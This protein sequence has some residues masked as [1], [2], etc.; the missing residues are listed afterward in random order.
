M[1]DTNGRHLRVGLT[2]WRVTRDIAGNLEVACRMIARAARDGAQLVLLPENA[3]ML[4]TSAEMR[5]AALDIDGPELTR[6]AD[7][8]RESD[9]VV[10]L[11][12]A[13]RRVPGDDRVRNTAV[14]FAADGSIVGG[15]DKVHLFDAQVGGQTFRAS[16]VESAGDRPVLLDLA[17]TLAGLTICYDVRFPELYRKLSRAGA[18]VLLIPAAF[19][20]HTGRAHWEVLLR[21]RAIENGAFVVAS[22]TVG[23]GTDVGFPTYGHALVV[24]PSGEVLADLQEATEAC[25]TV[26]LDLDCVA[27]A[28]EAIPVL[29]SV[30]PQA[31]QSDPETIR[32]A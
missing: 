32:I 7:A 27:T 9:V 8:A 18:E 19:T 24:S 16:T 10:V 23:S 2:Q 14:V 12:G 29:R 26:D 4:G 13:K 20:E 25:R 30:R 21:A 11:G 31:Y 3:L 15:Y 5:E 17:G 28:R 6:L 1:T 22:A